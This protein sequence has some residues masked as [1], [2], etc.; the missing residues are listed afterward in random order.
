VPLGVELG[1]LVAA[2]LAGTLLRF[3]LLRVWVFRPAAV[4]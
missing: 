4:G 3:L 1:V 2:N